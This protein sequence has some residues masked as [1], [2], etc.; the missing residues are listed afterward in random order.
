MRHH[1][2]ERALNIPSSSQLRVYKEEYEEHDLVVRNMICSRCL[3]AIRHDLE[4]LGVEILDLYL[5]RVRIQFP[6]GAI[7]LSVVEETL[8]A[9]DFEIVRNPNSEIAERIKLELVALINDLP[10]IRKSKLS[11]ILAKKLNY[12]YCALSKKFSKSEGISIEQYFIKLR[13]EK[14]K[15]LI[16]YGD[17]NFS[18]IAYDLG[19]NS[20]AHLSKQFKRVTGF[21]M[22]EFKSTKI[23]IRFPQ[24]KIE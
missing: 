22:S 1:I 15:E 24:D 23:K 20:I 13:V 12:S 11:Q 6:T 5:G 16:S 14:A 9:D 10:F 21:S 2:T 7:S 19:Y 4:S 3:K 8:L 17:S 18:E